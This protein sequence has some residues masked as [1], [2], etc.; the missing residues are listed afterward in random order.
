MVV[1]DIREMIELMPED[2]ILMKQNL[3]KHKTLTDH[4]PHLFQV[5]H[6]IISLLQYK[7]IRFAHTNEPNETPKQFFVC[8][9]H[10]HLKHLFYLYA[11]AFFIF[12]TFCVI[13]YSNW[14]TGI[15]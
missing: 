1:V 2:A 7:F 10:I 12:I 11:T 9:V 13:L 5:V 6:I 8:I 3:T 15:L 14:S 4:T